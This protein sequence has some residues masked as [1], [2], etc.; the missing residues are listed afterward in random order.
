MR[1][2]LLRHPTIRLLQQP[3]AKQAGNDGFHG[4]GDGQPRGVCPHFL[5][6]RFLSPRFS[7][8]SFS[9]PSLIPPNLTRAGLG[10]LR[11]LLV[12]GRLGG[13]MSSHVGRGIAKPCESHAL[14]IDM[15]LGNPPVNLNLLAL[16]AHI[17]GSRFPI[18]AHRDAA[19]LGDL[20]CHI[21]HQ[22]QT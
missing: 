17:A 14:A 3:L 11:L 1:M 12:R 18:H 20:A 8:P 10:L 2:T 19:V 9:L 13:Y 16:L 7:L 21:T 4:V 5:G 6:L 22:S 15:Y